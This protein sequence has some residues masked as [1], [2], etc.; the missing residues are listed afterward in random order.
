MMNVAST[1]LL[2]LLAFSFHASHSSSSSLTKGSSLSVEKPNDVI[3]SPNAVFSA[4]FVAIGENAYTFAIWFTQTQTQTHSHPT[5]VWMANR[6][7]PVN[8]KRSKLSLLQTGNL[9]LFD[10]GQQNVWS[11]NT[12]SLALTELRLK[13]DGN[14]V[15]HE[16]QGGNSLL[17]WQSF[18]FPTHTLL[19]GQPLTRHT[20]LV[21]SRS[22]SNHSS[23]FYKL[24]FD[25]DNVLRLI[26]DGPDVSS[27]YWPNPWL[28]SWD[29]GR[30]TYN[31]SR[32]AA[33]DS[34]GRFLSSDD[35]TF[36]TSDYGVVNKRRL[37]IDCDGNLR[38]YTM[39]DDESNRWFVSWQAR[40]D[41]CNIHGICGANSVCS[42]DAKV[43]RKC[44]C[45]PGHRVKNHS[46]WSYGCEPLFVFTCNGS[47][48]SFL[49][50][51]GVEI[52]GYDSNYSEPNTLAY[53]ENLCLEDCNCKGFQYSYNDGE[54]HFKC[55]TKSQLL[56]GRST[57][58][59]QGTMYLRVPKNHSRF[60]QESFVGY[61][62][63]VCFV[64]IPR[65]Y[66]GDHVSRILRFFL[67]VAVAVGGFETVCIFVVWVFVVRTR[68]KSSTDQNG[69]HVVTNR[70]RK[71]SYSELKKATKGFS[72]EIGKGGGGVVYKGILSDQRHAAIKRLYEA[73][74]GEG[75]FLAEVSIIGR[76]NH[77]NLIEMWGYCAEGKHRLL[78][79]EYMENGSLAQKLSSNTL[80]WD[81][82]YN[83]ALGVA[84]VLAYL[85]E[86]C[87][88]WIL[89]CDI[90]PQNILLDSSYEPKVADFGLSKLL[91]RNNLNN[92][93][94]SMIRGTRGYMAPEWV[95]NLA[96]TSKVD[97]YSYGIVLLEMITGK[98]PIQNIDGE[99]SYN[100][101]LVTWVREK[102]SGTSWLE[103]IIDPAIKT[104]YDECKMEI[105]VKV[106]LHCVEE[107]KDIR[108]T[109]SQVL[110]ML[111]SH[112]SDPQ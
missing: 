88:E 49:E 57:P 26:Y 79:Y 90:K 11:S 19:P 99:D 20:Q 80:D 21:S 6:E 46:D 35:F 67:W 95:L 81:K 50:M 56:N 43:G 2:F 110:E 51:P 15:L 92:S 77:M 71:Y 58:N 94:F 108:P 70:F 3:V 103:H 105:L 104:N 16:F 13:D 39:R 55:Y 98:S 22:E 47:E 65:V 89:H 8:G 101:R 32:F 12:V 97:V 23:G 24:F 82:R 86:E 1:I 96:I 40:A 102:R 73:K 76:L 10:A 36:K 37:K 69:Y 100:G 75:E 91:N 83:I 61:N 27:V 68:Q 66:A 30:S 38:V 63:R 7:N 48:S 60:H 5:M 52:Y 72:E 64:Q 41:T 29:A 106:A 4:G 18:D 42:Y 31:S 78:V 109:M 107:D 54:N 45:L 87:L 44:S 93:S 9:V 74:Q 53:C 14:L 33:L 62:T 28:V 17:L 25:D 112:E 59:F 84:R 34:L 85:H 111:Q